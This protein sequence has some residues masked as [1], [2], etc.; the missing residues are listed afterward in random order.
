MEDRTGTASVPGVRLRCRTITKL[1]LQLCGMECQVRNGDRGSIEIDAQRLRYF[2]YKGTERRF[3]LTSPAPD[4]AVLERHFLRDSWYNA[5]QH[6]KDETRVLFWQLA[7]NFANAR[8]LK[9]KVS[10]LE[11]IAVSKARRTELLCTFRNAVRLELEAAHH[12]TSK[13]AAVAIATLLRCC[14][15]VRDL[16]LKL[17]TAPSDFV[18][19]PGYG[20]LFLERK[21]RLDYDKSV[22]RYMRRHRLNPVISLDDNNKYDELLDIPGLSGHSFACLQGSLRRVGLQF[23]LDNSS[24]FG[25]RLVKF[26]TD[27]AR[28]LEEIRVDSGNRKLCEHMNLNVERWIAPT[29]SKVCLKRKNFTESSW[30]FSEMPRQSPNSRT[31]LSELATSFTVLPLE[32]RM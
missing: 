10:Y 5:S 1:V 26:F 3:S 18:K 14:P 6:H 25:I 15:V 16:R 2:R 8:A 29:S 30:K 24:C 23:R 31:D 11:D 13:A 28:L 17:T 9:L 21:A 27:N 19:D 4:M 32:R 7:R 22:N 12:P 20:E